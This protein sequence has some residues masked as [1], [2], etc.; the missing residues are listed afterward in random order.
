MK[1]FKSHNK[2]LLFFGILCLIFWLF[3]FI[4]TVIFLNRPSWMFSYSSVGLLF[5]SISLLSENSVL[6]YSSFC[7]LFFME[8]I[9]CID[10]IYH[11]VFQKPLFN[12]S[13]YAFVSGYNK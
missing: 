1:I 12:L 5:V 3:D 10:F 4:H 9:F 11:L 2:L 8:S 6:I 13:N 7:S